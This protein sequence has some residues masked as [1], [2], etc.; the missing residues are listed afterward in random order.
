MRLF[1]VISLLAL[2][3][4]CKPSGNQKTADKEITQDMKY[5]LGSIER[6][7]PALG[8]VLAP[9]AIIEV[10]SSGYEWTEGP[11]WVPS[12]KMLLFSDIPRNSIFKW[13]EKDGATLFLKPAGFTGEAERKG[14]PGSNGL[15]LDPQDRLVLCQHGDR[16]MARLVG[17]LSNPKATYE[18]LVDNYQGKRFNSPNDATY[19]KTGDL[20]FTDPPYG[21]EGNMDDPA[22]EIPFQGVYLLKAGSEVAELLIDTLSRPNGIALSP[23]ED[24]IYVANSDPE[25]AIWMTYELQDGRLSEGRVFYD[26]TSMVGREK[27]LPDGL[28]VHSSGVIFATGP[29]GV[30]V[31]G[32][33]GTVLGKIKTGQATANC[34]LD[35]DEK[36]LYITADMYLL[37]I[38]LA[39]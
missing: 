25:K 6:Y 14:E 34:A 10:L 19:S 26:A 11:L 8:Q 4:A 13:T 1:I 37:R 9:E 15:L 36:Y 24:R 18:T 17:G 22:K 29:G 38:R 21:L 31:F 7:D 32:A 33:D 39:G 23:K 12:E 30:W 5:T 35:N 27:G 28:K 2:F 16:R 20:Y 3:L